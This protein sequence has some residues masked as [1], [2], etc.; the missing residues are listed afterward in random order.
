M[1]IIWPASTGW[2]SKVT[3]RLVARSGKIISFDCLSSSMSF[4]T[5]AKEVFNVPWGAY[6][7][8]TPSMLLILVKSNYSTS[9]LML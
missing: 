1:T 4:S 6:K 8:H 9:L 2:P 5:L 7:E 3:S